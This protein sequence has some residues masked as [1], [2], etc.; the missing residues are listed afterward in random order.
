MHGATAAL[1]SSD[2]S[3]T[4][5]GN[6]KNRN[7]SW[8]E[9]EV[10]MGGKYIA[11]LGCLNSLDWTL[12]CSFLPYLNMHSHKA[13]TK[14]ESYVNDKNNIRLLSTCQRVI[15]PCMSEE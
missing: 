12:E 6:N 3:E 2:E 13:R 10:D 7:C 5:M 14:I 15:S 1:V 4:P 9:L 8:I 11:I